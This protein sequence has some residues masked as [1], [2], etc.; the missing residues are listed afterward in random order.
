MMVFLAAISFAIFFNMTALPQSWHM[1]FKPF[2]CVPCLSVWSALT[3]LFIPE[4]VVE[5][6]A[7]M[8]G[9]GVIGAVIYRLIH[10]L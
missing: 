5:Q 6:I 4:I 7:I 1:N 9:A 8:F 10:K 2:N 3:F